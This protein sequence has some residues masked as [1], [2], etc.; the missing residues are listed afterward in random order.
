MQGKLSCCPSV[1]SPSLSLS[2]F[3]RLSKKQG[4]GDS[5]TIDGHPRC[6]RA[7]FSTF[8]LSLERCEKKHP[9]MLSSF[10][11]NGFNF[12]CKQCTVWAPLPRTEP[13][14]KSPFPSRK[15]KPPVL[16][17]FSAKAA[18]YKEYLSWPLD[19]G[20]LFRFT[21]SGLDPSSKVLRSLLSAEPVC[22]PKIYSA[23]RSV[24]PYFYSE[25]CRPRSIAQEAAV[26]GHYGAGGVCREL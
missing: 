19:A 7:P 12:R 26:E 16:Q 13:K 10:V 4:E 1:F 2:G 21:F 6:W 8:D 22:F 14:P 23:R 20:M 3:T 9:W 24:L 15:P 17:A 18:D 5:S 11:S 25:S